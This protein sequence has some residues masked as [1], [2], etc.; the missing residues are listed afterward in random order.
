M[1]VEYFLDILLEN[2]QVNRPIARVEVAVLPEK[3]AVLPEKVAVLPE[4]VAVLPDAEPVEVDPV[5]VV[6]AVASAGGR[7][8]KQAVPLNFFV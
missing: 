2:F 4:R 1:T 3:V 8:E 6:P 7:R 5:P